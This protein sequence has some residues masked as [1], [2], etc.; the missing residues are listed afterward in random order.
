MKL[1]R[2]LCLSVALICAAHAG[3]RFAV[4]PLDNKA[5]VRGETERSSLASD[6][7][8]LDRYSMV[9]REEVEAWL[10][11]QPG[12][13]VM[14]RKDLDKLLKEIDLQNASGLVDASTAIPYGNFKGVSHLVGG[15]I[16]KI[17]RKA[18]NF[19]G[20]GI[21][22]TRET[23]T[24]RFRMKFMDVS[25]AELAYSGTYSVSIPVQQTGNASNENSD[26]Y[27]DLAEKVGEQLDGDE[28]L[29]DFLEAMTKPKKS[30]SKSAEVVDVG[31]DT[32][33]ESAA[34]SGEKVE[35]KI[36]PSPDNCD[37]EIA[38]VSVGTSP[39][40]PKLVEGRQVVIRIT[41]PGYLPWQQRVMVS[42]DMK[43]TP[44]LAKVPER[45]PAIIV[46]PVK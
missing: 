1:L 42:K 32:G 7:D 45:K 25:K 34:V 15:S 46:V 30:K 3:P 26:M 4:L 28:K 13:K 20:Y 37:V 38:G 29:K 41:K 23:Y 24:L 43:L 19:K 44:E 11:Q 35:V 6:T 9:I 12:V 22:A 14:E 17:S 21:A 10:T 8:H 16:L 5:N 40:K 27:G 39:V 18:T 33:T 2:S 31:D 36:D